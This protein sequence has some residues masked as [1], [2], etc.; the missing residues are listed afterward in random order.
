MGHAFGDEVLSTL[1]H[2]LK[3]EFR[4]N[5]IIGRT[6]GDEFI[7]L[8]KDLK[9][10]ATVKKEAG[11]VATFF[12]N[13]K[14]GEYTKYSATAS[15][16]AVEIP[17]DGVDFD[18]LY[19]A[20]DK[21]LYLAK[22][23]GKNQ[24]AFYSETKDVKIEPE[25]PVLKVAEEPAQ[26]GPEKMAEADRQIPVGKTEIKAESKV[27]ITKQPEVSVKETGAEVKEEAAKANVTGMETGEPVKKTVKKVV[28]RTVVKKPEDAKPEETKPQIQKETSV[29]NNPNPSGIIP[30]AGN[31][32]QNAVTVGGTKVVQKKVVKKVVQKKV[33][34][35]GEKP[36]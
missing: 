5:D 35:S 20:A 8:L 36:V 3:S 27:E 13:F 1:G 26:A 30:N 14:V 17:T 11:R 2:Q 15:I 12:K 10:D 25:K 6:G 7:I 33:V 21:A 28:K 31:T 4:I 24:M 32:A 19:K 29:I 23:R 16:G 18:T 22:K 9:D 34:K